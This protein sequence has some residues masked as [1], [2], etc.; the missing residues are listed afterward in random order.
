M[1]LGRLDILLEV[2][3]LSTH[4][5]LPRE[6]HLQQVCHIFGYLK[7]YPRQRIFM[8]LDD[9]NIDESI[10]KRFYWV[11]FYIYSEESIPIDILEPRDKRMSTHCFVDANICFRQVN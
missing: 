8:D 1:E 4:L 11:Y 6:G 2:D 9:P 3:L 10:Y 7:K 5:A